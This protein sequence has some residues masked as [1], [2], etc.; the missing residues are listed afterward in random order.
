MVSAHKNIYVTGEALQESYDS[1]AAS[2]KSS[3]QP[4]SP[5]QK[6]DWCSLPFCHAITSRNVSYLTQLYLRINMRKMMHESFLVLVSFT[7]GFLFFEHEGGDS[8][9]CASFRISLLNSKR[10]A[11]ASISMNTYV[12]SFRPSICPSETVPPSTPPPF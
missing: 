9:A 2:P 4:L 11:C 1:Q 3:L 10:R 5:G 7:M 8:H 12:R 6:R